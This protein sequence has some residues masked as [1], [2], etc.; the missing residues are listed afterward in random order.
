MERIMAEANRYKLVAVVFDDPYKAEEARAALH[1]MG[2]EGLLEIDETALIVKYADGRGRVSQ[3]VNI[4]AN[5]E[6]AGHLAGLVT[7]AITG[8]FPFI[9]VGTLGGWLVG[10]IID[11]GI[12]NSSIAKVKK[13]VT[14]GTSALILLARSDAERRRKVM[15]RLD[16]L[17]PKLIES[18]LPPDVERELTQALEHEQAAQASPRA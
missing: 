16:P 7:A 17:K 18:D 15:E 5:G 12:T 14:P 4:A 13:E 2:G 3:D 1:R 8:R 9:L 10:K 6:K 11:H